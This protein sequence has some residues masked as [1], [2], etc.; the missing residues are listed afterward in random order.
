MTIPKSLFQYLKKLKANNNRDWFTA[1]KETY[2][3][4]Q[5][6]MKGFVAQLQAEMEQFD[7]IER[8]KL[9]RIYRD[10]RFSK[11][12]TPYKS[13]FG[14]WLRRATKQ[15]R[16]GYYFHIEPNNTMVAGGFWR[17]NGP[18]LKRIRQEIAANDQELRTIIS[19][20]VF[21]KTFGTLL[22]ESV[23][24]SPRGYSTD[25]PAIDLLR[26]K[27]FV[28]KRHFKDKEVL[29]PDFLKEVIQT[30]LAMRPFFD[31]MSDVL[32][33]D[34]NGLSLDGGI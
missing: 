20:P 4:H 33:T 23:K 22:G 6:F 31:Y 24:T 32:T 21:Q 28:V 3:E 29:H 26:K 34:G 12:K 2:Q 5:I 25:H 30:F 14:G 10:V 15:R 11:D 9:Y 13:H 8:A 19:M 7:L 27:Q 16:G 1:N 18:D 17:P